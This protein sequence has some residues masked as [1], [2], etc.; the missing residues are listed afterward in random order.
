M[1][2]EG[3]TVVASLLASMKEAALKL[4]DALKHTDFEQV[5]W[6]TS[7]LDPDPLQSDA[8]F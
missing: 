5:A 7:W 4:Q 6:L 2:K 1:D 3:L 8:A